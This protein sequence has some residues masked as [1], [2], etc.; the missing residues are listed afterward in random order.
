[1][2]KTFICRTDEVGITGG[3]LSPDH[4]AL[5]GPMD[6][7][8]GNPKNRYIKVTCKVMPEDWEPKPKWVTPTD[9][10]AKMRPEVKVKD[11]K[12]KAVQWHKNAKL[13]AVIEEASKPF[14]VLF[15][16]QS[17]PTEW[18]YCRMKASLRKKE[19]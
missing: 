17:I 19:V 16:G 4:V 13:L 5:T 3:S 11:F 9:E 7:K 12:E 15:E 14:I 10:D 18:G 1:M 2:K 8:L 6:K